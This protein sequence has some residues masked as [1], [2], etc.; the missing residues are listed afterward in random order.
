M[1]LE[2]C[3][4]PLIEYVLAHALVH[5]EYPYHGRISGRRWGG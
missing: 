2:V 3:W 4:I 5:L 1:P